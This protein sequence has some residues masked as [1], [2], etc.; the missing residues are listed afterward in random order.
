MDVKKLKWCNEVRKW[1]HP[2]KQARHRHRRNSRQPNEHWKWP[3]TGYIMS[4][5]KLDVEVERKTTM[6]KRPPKVDVTRIGS[7]KFEFQLELRNR[8]DTQQELDDINT[9]SETITYMI[10]QSASRVAKAINKPHKSRISSPTRALMT[11]RWQMS[12]NG[13]TNQRIEY[14]E[15]YKTIKKK[16]REDIMGTHHLCKEQASSLTNKDGKEN[17]KHHL[18]GQKNKHLGKKKDQGQRR[19]WTSQK[20]EVDLGRARQQD[21]R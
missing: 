8:F 21:T 20:T 4:N 14:A 16:A 2:N 9:T 17:V 5:I 18:P 1:L 3:Q 11:R 15:I 13:D 7:K 6:T 19:D 10:Q 12:G